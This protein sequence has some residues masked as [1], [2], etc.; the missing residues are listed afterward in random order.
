MDYVLTT[1][2]PKRAPP[3]WAAW[4]KNF[5][6]NIQPARSNPIITLMA[7]VVNE[8]KITFDK[9]IRTCIETY[10]SRRKIQHRQE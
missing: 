7:F 8:N 3:K 1:Y 9:T 5:Q 10:R 2:S 6:P 4:S